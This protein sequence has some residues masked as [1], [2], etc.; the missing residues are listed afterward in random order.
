M[1]MSYFWKAPK[2]GGWLLG[3]PTLGCKVQNL[4]PYLPDLLRWKL[5]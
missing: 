1:L 2:D 5:T 3:E 4:Q